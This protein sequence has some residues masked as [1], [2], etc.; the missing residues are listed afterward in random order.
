MRT[1]APWNVVESMYY[2]TDDDYLFEMLEEVLAH[3]F[4]IIVVQGSG[5]VF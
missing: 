2:Y 1:F 4:Y 3:P 5:V